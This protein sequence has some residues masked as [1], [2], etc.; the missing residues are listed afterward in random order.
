MEG[1]HDI[2]MKFDPYVLT[3]LVQRSSYPAAVQTNTEK[4]FFTSLGPDVH[5]SQFMSSHIEAV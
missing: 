3:S 2:Q 1:H 5:S 4:T